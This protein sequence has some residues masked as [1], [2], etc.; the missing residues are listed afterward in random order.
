[1]FPN[2]AIARKY[3]CTKTAA[4]VQAMEDTI[5]GIVNL[6]SNGP[7]SLA[8]GCKLPAV[9][10]SLVHSRGGVVIFLF[11]PKNMQNLQLFQL[12]FDYS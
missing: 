4:I 12:K 6:M 9:S 2:S 1:M 10:N 5:S 8:I 11:L 7:Y 3:N